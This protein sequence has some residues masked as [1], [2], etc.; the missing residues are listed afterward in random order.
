MGTFFL[1][2]T[3]PSPPQLQKLPA[4][5]ALQ[6]TC[7]GTTVPK[8]LARDRPQVLL[9][10]WALHTWS[11]LNIA[12]HTQVKADMCTCSQ[13]NTS[14]KCCLCCRHSHKPVSTLLPT[15]AFSRMALGWWYQNKPFSKSSWDSSEELPTSTD[16]SGNQPNHQL[17]WGPGSPSSPTERAHTWP[18]DKGKTT[19]KHR[20]GCHASAATSATSHVRVAYCLLWMSLQTSKDQATSFINCPTGPSLVGACL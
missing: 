8:F 12:Y 11:S 10:I 19:M 20:W 1:P 16:F 15:K 3:W 6:V 9:T 2:E 5:E 4:N 14:Q 18:P 17:S 7:S 13:F